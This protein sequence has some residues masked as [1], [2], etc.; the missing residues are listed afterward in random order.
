MLH[1]V[2]FPIMCFS[3]EDATLF[4]EDPHEYIRKVAACR[5]YRAVNCVTAAILL[6]IECCPAL[7]YYLPQPHK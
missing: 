5:A 3:D 2:A 4:D 6:C 7:L 1:N